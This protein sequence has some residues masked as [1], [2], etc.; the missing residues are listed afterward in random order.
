MRIIV[1]G[2][3]KMLYFLAK[4][5][6][7]ADQHVT[8]ITNQLT[9]ATNLSRH[10]EGIVVIAGDGSDPK[11][12]NDAQAYRADV[13]LSLTPFDQNNLV[14]CQ[15]ADKMFGVPKTIALVNDPDNTEL[16]R[17]LGVTVAFSATRI[18][19]NLIE[20][21][22]GF[23]EITNLIPVANGLV[24]ITETKLPPDSPV[25]GKSLTEIPLPAN[26]L[27]SCII[28]GDKEVII[29]RGQ[30]KLMAYDKVLILTQPENASKAL[31]ILTGQE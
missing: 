3:G 5:F 30:T 17:R 4:Q 25:I 10:L 14:A 21:Q 31:T 28:R 13:L 9:E 27:I 23:Q 16:F 2:A 8:V 29:P 7:Q 19:A 18:I 22:T 26:A 1:V 24:T 20:Q 12:L 11:V 6:S 15:I